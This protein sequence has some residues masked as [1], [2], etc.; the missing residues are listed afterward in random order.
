MREK[1]VRL[2][3]VWDG[4]VGKIG[5]KLKYQV[6][7]EANIEAERCVCVCVCVC[8]RVCD[9][10]QLSR[11]EGRTPPGCM[12]EAEVRCGWR[13]GRNAGLVTSVPAGGTEE[14]HPAETG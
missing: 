14:S 9:G 12:E 7:K 5:G 11:A 4:R 10:G 6:S 13:E 1:D 3:R 8:V 2:E